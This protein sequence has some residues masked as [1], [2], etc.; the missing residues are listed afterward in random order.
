MRKENLLTYTGV[1]DRS[2]AEESRTIRRQ[3]AL[4]T[5]LEKLVVERQLA[6]DDGRCRSRRPDLEPPHRSGRGLN[7]NRLGHQ[8]G[9]R[10]R[11]QLHRKQFKVYWIRN[12][13]LKDRPGPEMVE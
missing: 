6:R 13:F 11:R 8:I 5:L 4:S 10:R 9:D 3:A 7:S 12:F 1:G 2:D